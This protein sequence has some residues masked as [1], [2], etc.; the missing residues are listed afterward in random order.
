MTGR[1]KII[2]FLVLRQDLHNGRF[3]STNPMDMPKYAGVSVNVLCY[4]NQQPQNCNRFNQDSFIFHSYM[5]ARY[6]SALRVVFI[7]EPGAALRHGNGR[8][9]MEA[10]SISTCR[11]CFSIHVP[12]AKESDSDVLSQGVGR[13]LLPTWK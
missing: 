4:G 11:K 12:L 8:K 1:N 9:T 6:S 13:M 2:K 7:W 5:W 10:C 3:C